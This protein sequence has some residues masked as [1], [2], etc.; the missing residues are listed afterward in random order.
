MSYSF[1]IQAGLTHFWSDLSLHISFLDAIVNGMLKVLVSN[2]QT[3]LL[4]H[5]NTIDFCLLVMYLST[6]LN[7]L[8]NYKCFS[9]VVD[10]TGFSI[11]QTCYLWLKIVFLLPFQPVWHLFLIL[12]LLHWLELPV[13]CH[14]E[15]VR[16]ATLF[17][18]LEGKHSFSPLHITLAI[19]FLWMDT[20]RMRKLPSISH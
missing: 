16:T 15:V 11:K 3:F 2:F 19:S 13:Q 10:S 9:V 6:W 17:L 14:I 1:N 12:S 5:K 20:I 8:K 7:S 4:V 18:T